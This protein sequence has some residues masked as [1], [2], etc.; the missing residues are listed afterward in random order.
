M[1]SSSRSSPG[2]CGEREV[3]WVGCV[4][5]GAVCCCVCVV[6][7]AVI[8]NHSLPRPHEEGKRFIRR[9]ETSFHVRIYRRP[10]TRLRIE[11]SI[12]WVWLCVVL[13]LSRN[14]RMHQ[15]TDSNSN[16]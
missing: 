7:V 12:G 14:P 2:W 10:I 4:A 5:R 16:M 1:Y 8:V 9:D 11:P 6:L 13:A 3:V 15:P